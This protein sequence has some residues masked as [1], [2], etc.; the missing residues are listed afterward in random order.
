MKRPNR[1][2]IAS[3]L[4]FALLVLMSG[5]KVSGGENAA[6]KGGKPVKTF[7]DF[8]IGEPGSAA[9]H[10]QAIQLTYQD[11]SKG[12]KTKPDAVVVFMGPAVKLVSKN[13]TGFSAADQKSLDEI[14]ATITQLSKDGVKFELCLFAAKV[15]GVDPASVLPEIKNVPNGWISE[16]SYQ[17][18]GYYL[19]PVY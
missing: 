14:A 13:R 5:A 18:Q 3:A 2:A 11:L 12:K 9:M 17:S 10:L 7:F 8:R 19:V 15:M 1:T 6:L 16:I 4:I